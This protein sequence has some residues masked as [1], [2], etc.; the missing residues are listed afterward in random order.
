[1]S[2]YNLLW[3][4]IKGCGK[5]SIVLTFEEIYNAVG[6]EIDH[7]FLNAKKELLR[8]GYKVGKISIKSQTVL[9]E[10]IPDNDTL[11]VYVHGKG[12]NVAEA[13][14]YKSLFPACEVIGLDYE[15]ETP[16]EAKSEFSIAFNKISEN[17]SCVIL[18][19]N[20][21]G[22]YFSMC[23]LPPK[24]IK[25]AY[26]VSPIVD[27]E[28]VVLDMMKSANVMESDLQ[29]KKTIVTEWGETLSW[30]YLKYVRFNPIKWDVSTEILYGEKDNLTSKQTIVDFANA[31]N[32]SLTIMPNGEHWFHTPEQM[33]FL[34]DWIINGERNEKIEI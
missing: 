29:A 4:Y 28:R 34:D 25:R 32:V 26:F 30:D 24:K 1:M 9:F 8:H 2:K 12:G 16:W 10:K 22:A 33:K 13:E 23:A 3:D 18:I 27:M 21:I 17:Y 14:H 31:H 11:V 5:H 6:V 7:S 19:A 15:A 20:S